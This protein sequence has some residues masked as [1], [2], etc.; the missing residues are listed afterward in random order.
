MDNKDRKTAVWVCQGCGIGEAIDVEALKKLADDE[1]SVDLCL[2]HSC[3]CSD[4][5]LE[6]VKKEIQQGASTLV[7][8]AC[9]P[10]FL[11]DT[12]TFDGCFTERVN[13]RESSAELLHP[14]I[15]CQFLCYQGMT[16]QPYDY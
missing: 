8:A 7:I 16:G 6:S 10:R 1:S 13:L 9:S 11:T 4:E 12:F 2:S 14:W 15:S 3:L 5:G